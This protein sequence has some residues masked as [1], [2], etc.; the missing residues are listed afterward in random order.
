M[1][2]QHW[3]FVWCAGRVRSA[4]RVRCLFGMQVGLDL[5][6]VFDVGVQ[7]GGLDLLATLVFVWYAGRVRSA[8][9][10]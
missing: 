4:G 8:G 3:C 7:V 5:L 9:N 10:V 2:W 6:A 1:C